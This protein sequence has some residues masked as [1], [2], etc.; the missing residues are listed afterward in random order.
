M[1]QLKP[2]EWHEQFLANADKE[3]IL[4]H[5]KDG[6]ERDVTKIAVALAR[7]CSLFADFVKFWMMRVSDLDARLSSERYMQRIYV[8]KRTLHKTLRK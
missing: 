5:L 4:Q 6:Q 2:K 3:K 8:N 7:Q 1:K